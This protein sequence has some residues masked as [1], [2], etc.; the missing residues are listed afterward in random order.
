MRKFALI[1]PVFV[2]LTACNNN[3]SNQ[4]VNTDFA[5]TNIDTT[6]RA[7]DDFF[8]FANGS[9][10]KNNPIPKEESAWG[11]GNMVYKENL[12]RLKK[13][14]EDAAKEKAE[15]GSVNQK[16]GS[17][18]RT[19]MDT[20][21]IEKAGIAPIQFLL[22][23]IANIKNN[24]D[25]VS[26]MALLEKHGIQQFIASYV[27]QDDKNS[28]SVVLKFW[29]GGLN[30]P[31]REYYLNNDDENKKIREAYVLYIDK[32]LALIGNKTTI[33][34]ASA[35]QI[36]ALETQIAKVHKTLAATRDSEKNYFKMSLNQFAALSKSLNLK[37]YISQISTAKIDTIIVGQ[38]EYY[39]NFDKIFT[40]QNLNTI[41]TI[42]TF[43]VVNNMAD[44]LPKAYVDASFDFE[45]VFSGVTEQKPRWKNVLRVEEKVMGEL[46]GQLY[47]KEYFND[48]A[49]K[50]YSDLVEAIKESLA[51][52]ITKL[53]WMSSATKTKAL[54][55]L[56][57]IQKKV[58]YPDKWKDLSTLE[59]K[60]NSYAE[61]MLQSN[62]WWHNYEMNKIGKP[63]DKETWDMTPQTYNAY[64]NPSLNEIV[65]PAAI[66]A[67]PGLKDEDVD[68]AIV[69]GYAGATTIGHEITHGFDD[70]GRKFDKNGNLTNWWTEEDGNKFM[71]RAQK[72]INQFNNFNPID[73]LHIN[74]EA[75]LG[76][77]IADL[78]G[79]VIAWDAFIKTKAYQENKAINGY[80][81]AQRF[82]LGYAL[83]WLGHQRNEQLRN[84]LMTD[85]HSPAK[86]RVNG[87]FQSVPAFYEVWQVKPTDKMFVADSLRVNIW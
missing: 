49:K 37:T 29:Q 51:N 17:F 27:S 75:T 5:A 24:N 79:A 50:R 14:N 63:V 57:T 56:A 10:I 40:P 76:E 15:K 46:L 35:A 77:N 52:R 60:D 2:C 22:D 42:L 32:I 33:Q 28:S 25:L 48:K 59:I 61:N 53:D 44:Y 1:I 20:L 4:S 36:L 34:K 43:N 41:K 6:V 58:G 19:A 31:E 7:Q 9:W 84:R 86:Y 78:G 47:V 12:D 65:L 55:K 87:V 30:L 39:K 66:F 8:A 13:I 23:S 18:W 64:Y 3:N 82:F 71:G 70:E 81:P 16:I 45:K 69:Y 26:C 73:K 38:P 83:G 72:M 80:T 85:V 67:I 54:D 11:I 74:G 21:A 68:D 62:I